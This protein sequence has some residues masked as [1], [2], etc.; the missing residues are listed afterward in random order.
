MRVKN[1]LRMEFLT[2]FRPVF[3]FY[4][5]WKHQKTRGFVTFSGGIEG[6]HWPEM[7]KSLFEIKTHQVLQDSVAILPS[8]YMMP[9]SSYM[10]SRRV[11]WSRKIN[12][13]Q[14]INTD[15]TNTSELG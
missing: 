8:S 9:S 13:F 15:V 5:R 11:I 10:K 7:G 12:D 1:V 2:H 4:T 14:T 3:P 6:E